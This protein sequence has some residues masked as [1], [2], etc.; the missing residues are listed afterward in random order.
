MKEKES[1]EKKFHPASAKPTAH[2]LMK[3]FYKG[4]V[5]RDQHKH[6]AKEGIHSRR[7]ILVHQNFAS[8]YPEMRTASQLVTRRSGPGDIRLVIDKA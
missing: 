8:C 1:S 3:A 5:H 2:L 6:L 7:S 4:K